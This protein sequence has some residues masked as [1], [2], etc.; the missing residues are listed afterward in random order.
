M[1]EITVVFQLAVM[2]SGGVGQVICVSLYIVFLKV[3][4]TF[5][6]DLNI[7]CG[8]CFAWQCCRFWT[9][10][11][12]FWPDHNSSAF[13]EL[14]LI[15]HRPSPYSV[16]TQKPIDFLIGS[17]YSIEANTMLFD[18]AIVLWK[19]N[20]RIFCAMDFSGVLTNWHETLDAIAW[21]NRGIGGYCKDLEQYS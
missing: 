14:E 3:T 12:S 19:S 1:E 17:R 9:S 13:L 18:Q 11:I 6:E 16:Y 7:S 20:S 2:W 8:A 21:I 15:L 4:L 5:F 10:S